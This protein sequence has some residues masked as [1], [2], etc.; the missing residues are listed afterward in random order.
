MKYRN[1]FKAV[2]SGICRESFS[3]RGMAKD[4]MPSGAGVEK[5]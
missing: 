2:E 1:V 5:V 4:I 3:K